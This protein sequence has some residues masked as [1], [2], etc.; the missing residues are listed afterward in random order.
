M[1][2]GDEVPSCLQKVLIP[3]RVVWKR[4]PVRT[5]RGL[6]IHFSF[7]VCTALL[8]WT[9]PLSDCPR[10]QPSCCP[11][12]RKGAWWARAGPPLWH[13]Q[14]HSHHLK[15]QFWVYSMISKL[16]TVQKIHTEVRFS[17][18]SPRR[19]SRRFPAP[20]RRASVRACAD[21]LSLKGQS[22]SEGW[23]NREEY[24]ESKH[25]TSHIL[26]KLAEARTPKPLRNRYNHSQVWEEG[27]RSSRSFLAH[28]ECHRSS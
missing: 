9:A 8:K 23:G 6:Q 27:M 28:L 3:R 2:R 17:K 25:L 24:L 7:N 21:S 19:H 12:V 10:L 4:G 5:T 13:Q 11:T 22:K 16:N 18:V 15:L 1:N 14:D 26:H 20:A